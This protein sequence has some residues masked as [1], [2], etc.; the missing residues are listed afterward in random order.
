MSK[1]E[2]RPECFGVPEE[3]IPRDEETGFIITQDDCADCDLLSD[4]LKA[5]LEASAEEIGKREKERE[6]QM[7]PGYDAYLGSRE[8]AEPGEEAEPRGVVGFLKRWS[9]MK[10]EKKEKE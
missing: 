10:R 5:A 7:P 6:G 8:E 3:V 2:T 1:D 4:C 9:R